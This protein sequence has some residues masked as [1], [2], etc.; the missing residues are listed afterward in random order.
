MR[1]VEP[2][3]A[4][5]CWVMVRNYDSKGSFPTT[6]AYIRLGCSRYYATQRNVLKGSFLHTNFLEK[7]ELE[8]A[9]PRR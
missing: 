4:V 1:G 9:G 3:Q 7:L 6:K 8:K 5:H 2:R